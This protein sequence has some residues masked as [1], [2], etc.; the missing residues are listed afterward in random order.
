MPIFP[1]EIEQS[2]QWRRC[3]LPLITGAIVMAIIWLH[4]KWSSLLQDQSLWPRIMPR[5]GP[6]YG[7][8][9]EGLETSGRDSEL[10]T[11]SEEKFGNVDVS[12]DTQGGG[13]GFDEGSYRGD[14]FGVE[15]FEGL[16]D[17]GQGMPVCDSIELATKGR[18]QELNWVPWAC[19]LPPS[20]GIPNLAKSGR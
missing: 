3:I 8:P 20:S 10:A 14:S 7:P 2:N 11:S 9:N 13:L 5:Q 16:P 17:L 19:K 6:P 15:I 4:I 12:R 1:S 18:W